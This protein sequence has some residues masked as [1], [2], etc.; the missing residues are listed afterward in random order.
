MYL[1]AVNSIDNYNY[2]LINCICVNDKDKSKTTSQPTDQ[3][4][5]N[6]IIVCHYLP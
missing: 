6:Y 3:I 2:L 5:T 1:I 4:S